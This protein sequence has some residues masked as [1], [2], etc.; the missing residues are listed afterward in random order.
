[1]SKSPA[2]IRSTKLKLTDKQ[3]EELAVKHEA[4]GFGIVDAHGFTTHGF[5]P[6]G[7]RTFINELIEMNSTQE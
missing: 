5:D 1:M 4:F 7:L 6:E 3:I 2:L